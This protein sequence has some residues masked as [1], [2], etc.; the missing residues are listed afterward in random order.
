MLDFNL[1]INTPNSELRALV[2][3]EKFNE[4]QKN[5]VE[6]HD[7]TCQCCGWKPNKEEGEDEG[8][9]DYKKKHLVLEVTNLS[10]ENPEFSE[11]TVLC[12]SC[13][14]INHI[15]IGVEHKF[16]QLVNA[17]V[18]QQDLIKMCWSDVSKGQILGHNRAKAET[19]KLF[20]KLKQ[21]PE[22]FV[23]KVR[24]GFISKSVKV[25]FTDSFLQK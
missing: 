6:Q 17:R 2:G 5:A 14:V 18:D 24:N 10:Q 7:H 13:Y 8:Q 22:E 12:R 1:K 16:V 25:V 23:E 11:T 4:L 21:D 19:D 15:D 9:Y 3:N 20:I